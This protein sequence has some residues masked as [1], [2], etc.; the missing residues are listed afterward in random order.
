MTPRSF[1]L[2]FSAATL[3]AAL[4]LGSPRP[5]R[6]E[7]DL[8][9]EYENYRESGR[10]TVQT[11]GALL[12]QD[13]TPDLHFQLGGV[14]DS[15]TGATP[16]GVPAPAGSK[17]V[18]LSHITD[19]RKAWNADLA[20]QIGRL[21][22]SGG[23]SRSLEHDYVSN[24]WSLNTS[25]DFNE[26]NTTLLVGAAGTDNTVQVFF[27]PVWLKKRTNDAIVGLTQIL[28]PQT[29][30]SLDATWS[31]ATG[32][33]AEPYKEV[34][35][36]VQVFP[37]IFLFETFPEELPHDHN[38]GDALLTLDH[39]FKAAQGTLEASYRF[40]HDTYGMSTD[41]IELAW[42]QHLGPKL[43]LR[44]MVRFYNQTAASFYYY[45]LPSSLAA[46]RFPSP[47]GPLYTSDARLS[48]YTSLS[49]GLKAIW[50]VTDTWQ[51][52]AGI[53]AY[54]QRGTDGITPQTA[55]Y[56]ATIGRFGAKYSW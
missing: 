38:K 20:E 3:V 41:T 37:T 44:P 26:K 16:S 10:I 4:M 9:F 19:R 34:L 31:R 17:Q 11:S 35:A 1:S 36:D 28:D 42:F 22:I 5:A 46:T 23:F 40:T 6:A 2:R 14:M 49:S 54:G 18:V 51:L 53:E 25:T 39:A 45:N 21:N 27:T 32:F 7:N 24:G 30:V 12:D 33:L 50:K 55:Y 13:L 47:S 43:I 29:T 48:A 52:T 15:I 56:R 8:S